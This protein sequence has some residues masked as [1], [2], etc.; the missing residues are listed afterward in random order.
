LFECLILQTQAHLRE[1]SKSSLNTVL[2]VVMQNAFNNIP[3]P[4]LGQQNKQAKSGIP[5]DVPKEQHLKD[6]DIS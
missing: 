1:S 4:N 3:P 6:A 2:A 5:S